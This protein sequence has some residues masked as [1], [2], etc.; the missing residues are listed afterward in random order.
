[1]PQKISRRLAGK[2]NTGNTL[3]LEAREKKEDFGEEPICGRRGNGAYQKTANYLCA[4]KILCIDFARKFDGN[5]FR[6]A[7]ALGRGRV[8]YEDV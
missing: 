7:K 8:G 5:G 6:R 4:G 2:E 1:M 3:F